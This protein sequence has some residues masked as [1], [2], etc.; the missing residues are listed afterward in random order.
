[1]CFQSM[2]VV[3]KTGSENYIDSYIYIYICGKRENKNESERKFY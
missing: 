1:M 2:L 3:N